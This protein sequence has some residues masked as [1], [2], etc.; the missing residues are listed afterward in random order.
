MPK[1]TFDFLWKRQYSLFQGF[2]IPHPLHLFIK[3]KTG[4]DAVVHADFIDG[5]TSFY[6]TQGAIGAVTEVLKNEANE[7]PEIIAKEIGLLH[8]TGEQLA[9]H[10]DNIASPQKMSDEELFAF[11][12]TFTKLFETYAKYLWASFYWP[13]AVSQ[14]FEDM[15]KEVVPPKH[16]QQAMLHYSTPTK[17]APLT[18]IAGFMRSENDVD[19]R[20]NYIKRDYPWLGT[21]DPTFPPMTNEQ[22]IELAN[23][24]KD[25]TKSTTPTKPLSYSVDQKIIDLYQEVLYMKDKRDEYRRVG[26]YKL[27]PV[28]QEIA[29]RFDLS[30][31]DFWHI[32]SNE[33]NRTKNNREAL[34][35]DIQKRKQATVIEADANG[36][37]MLSGRE[38]AKMVIATEE[39]TDSQDLHGIIGASGK[40]RGVIQIIRNERDIKTFQKDKILVATTTNPNYITAMQKASAFVTDEGGITCH[41]AIIA[42]EMKKP[43]IIGTKIATQVLKDGDEVEVDANKGIVTIINN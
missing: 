13:E 9:N 41:A 22:T 10:G 36:V 16:V 38:A 24:F 30:I 6:S 25:E 7:H 37:K 20:I 32:S 15:I 5:W 40:V 34:K 4:I 19:K 39:K 1:P 11:C 27:H 35:K 28:L 12:N 14:I 29:D 26:Y 21:T 23:S 33:T 42:R 2:S 17:Q 43:C 3:E 8:K 31:D 18:K